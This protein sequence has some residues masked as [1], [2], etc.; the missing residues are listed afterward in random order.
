M[1]RRSP[2]FNVAAVASLSIGIA[3]STAVFSAINAILWRS[4]PGVADS[5]RVAQVFTRSLGAV[6][7]APDDEY[8]GLQRSLTA[9][10]SLA[11][12]RQMPVAVDVAHE[13][14]T[15]TAVFVSGNYFD[16]LGTRPAA[17]RLL[18]DAAAHHQTLVVSHG[19]AMRHF[20][21]AGDALGRAVSINGQRLQVIGVAPPQFGG[22]HPGQFGDEGKMRPELWI[23]DA[24]EDSL[25]PP[26][27]GLW[28][29]LGFGRGWQDIIGRLAPGVSM[30]A[31]QKQ[32]SGLVLQRGRATVNVL[33]RPLGIG[34]HDEPADIA[35]AVALVLSIPLIVLAVGCANTA[36]LQLARAAHRQGELAVRLSLG[37][38]RWRIVRQ[39]MIE[40]LMTA[41]LAGAAGVAGAIAAVRVFGGMMPVPM[42]LDWRVLC[43]ALAATMATGVGF[44]MAPALAATRGDLTAPLKDS[45]A[46][47]TYRRSLTRS[48]LVV[49]QIALSLLLLVMAGL[50]TR[51]LDRLHGL[52]G[53]RRMS[54]VA[55]V[56]LDLGLLHYSSEQGESF[57][58]TLLAR[59]EEIPGVT[60]AAVAHF[61]PFRGTPGLSYRDPGEAGGPGQGRYT[62]G[63]GMYGRF[64]ETAGIRVVAG[65]DFTE[66]D[67]RGPPRV[68]LVSETLARRMSPTG[69]VLGRPLVVVDGKSPPADVTIVGIT[70]DAVQRIESRELHAMLLPAPLVYDP[71]FTVWLRTSGDPALALPHV[72]SIVRQL[73]PRVPIRSSGTAEDWRSREIGPFRW[74]AVSLGSMGMLA[75]ALAAAGLYAVM[76]YLVARRRQEMGI[77]IAL[78]ASP[79]QL[80]GL[81]VGEG[82][83]LTVKGVAAGLFLGGVAA[84]LARRML[85]GT[86][87]FDPFAFGAVSMLLVGVA[88][89]ATLFPALHASRLDPIATLRRQ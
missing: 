9:F 25:A 65:R 55:A 82:L 74:I 13:P 83:R 28:N 53:E 47:L 12:F 51:T 34:P 41:L 49:V 58:K 88:L 60:S 71:V 77:R 61:E 67:R 21:T 79:R 81:I 68:A 30:E 26:S 62:N 42:V 11:A 84:A 50:F 7:G 72:R 43:F 37:A 14:F 1:L 56:T 24:L 69:D 6:S 32:A 40:S 3:A 18:D 78:G 48:G 10:S 27:T 89:A 45:T 73:D 19:F 36:N 54:H 4:L 80:L 87:P 20:G 76:S 86:S 75:L 23:P 31:A 33:V 39:L 57:Q 8:A 66:A 2:G 22:V 16:V 46:S 52:D 15:A 85:I 64:T 44:G 59:V 63:G 29:R 70:A 17:G 35:L 5:G 38:S